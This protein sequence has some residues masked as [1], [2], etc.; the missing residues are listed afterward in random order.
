MLLAIEGIGN[1]VGEVS[2]DSWTWRRLERSDTPFKWAILSGLHGRKPFEPGAEPLQTIQRLQSV[3]NRLVHPK[4]LDFCTEL[5]VRSKDG[6]VR[7]RVQLDSKV[8]DGDLVMIGV[9]KLIDDG[10]NA[11]S[12]HELTEKA[13]KAIKDLRAHLDITGL[14][15]VDDLGKELD[16]I[17]EA[18][19]QINP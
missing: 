19:E 12:T 11:K 8:E 14:K 7:R 17:G 4:I 13:L 6:K 1:E 2:L 10:F 5:I 3:R 15:W 18:S 9:G 16:A